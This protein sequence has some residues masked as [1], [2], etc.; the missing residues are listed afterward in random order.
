MRTSRCVTLMFAG[1]PSTSDGFST[2]TKHLLA[3]AAVTALL[4]QGATAQT[5]EPASRASVKEATQEAARTKSL[6][7]AGEGQSVRGSDPGPRSTKTRAAGKSETRMER[8][9]G[10]LT[11]AGQGGAKPD[12]MNPVRTV[13][14]NRSAVKSETRAAEKAGTLQPAG[15]APQ[16]A[17]ESPKK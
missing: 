9:M 10:G 6:T 13:A 8:D 5:T 16:P 17:S 2:H 15:E 14:K 4:A 7:P 3:A 11:P 12:H 1:F